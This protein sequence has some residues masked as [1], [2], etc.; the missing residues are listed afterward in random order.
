[1]ETIVLL[2][3]SW[4]CIWGFM[5]YGELQQYKRKEKEKKAHEDWKRES[6]P[7]WHDLKHGNPQQQQAAREWFWARGVDADAELMFGRVD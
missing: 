5:K 3:L 6:A 4:G 1:M 2:V 7:Y